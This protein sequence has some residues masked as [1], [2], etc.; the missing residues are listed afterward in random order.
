[1]QKIYFSILF[2]FSLAGIADNGITFKE[3]KN[4][5]PANVLFGADYKS[6]RFFVNDNGFNFCMYDG[7][8]LYSAHQSKHKEK[9]ETRQFIKGHNYNVVFNNASFLKI[10]K[11][12]PSTEYYNYFIGNDESK[13]AGNV[14]AYEEL[15]FSDIYANID[16][17]LYSNNAN[18][19]YD[20]IVKPNGNSNQVELNYESVNSVFIKNDN[21]I[22]ETSV[23]NVTEQKPYAYQFIKGKKIEVLC[24]YKLKDNNTVI[25]DLPNGY[26]EKYDLII[27]PTVIVCSYDNS[28]VWANCHGATYDT[29]GNIFVLGQADAGYPTTAG[30]FQIICDSLYDNVITKYNS[31]GSSKIFTTYV[32]GDNYEFIQNAKVTNN[33]IC[34]FGITYSTNFPTTTN[35]FDRTFNDTVSNLCDLF[36][37][38]LDL[39]GSS[40]LASTYIG[41]SSND[42]VNS[43][44]V[45]TEGGHIGNMLIDSQDN[46]YVTSSTNSINFPTSS[47]AFQTI[48][49]A[50]VD[51]VAFKLDPTLHTLLYSTF[52]GGTNNENAFD[53]KLINGNEILISGTTQS[54]DFPT[55]SG[56]ISPIKNAGRDMYILHLNSTGTGILASTFI[57]SPTNEYA[58]FIDTDENN[59]IYLCGYMNATPSFIQTPGLYATATG[60]ST[61]YKVNSSLS[62]IIYKTKFGTSNFLEYTAFEVDS[63]HNIY[64]AAFTSGI[65]FP[66]TADKFQ[67]HNH[68]SD[69]YVS[70]FNT[71]MLSLKFASYF[72]GR[73]DEHVDGGTSYFTDKGVLYQGICINRGDL[74]TTPGAF[75]TTFPTVDTMAYNDAFVKIDLQ[76]FVTTTSSYGA[77]IKACSPF[78]ANFNSFANTGTNS[79]NFGD[80]SPISYQQ[81][82]S[83]TYNSIG[84]YTVLLIANDSTTCNKTDT[85]KS[86]I[87]VVNPSELKITG[88]TTICENQSVILRA[89]SN[90]AVSYSWSTGA[91]TNSISINTEGTYTATINNGGCD[92]KQTI[93]V[94]YSKSNIDDLFPNV[95]TPNNDNAN[96][97]IDLNKYNFTEVLFTVFDRWGNQKYQSDKIDSVFSP[98]GYTDGTYFYTLNYK[99]ACND[100]EV[101]TKGFIT[102]IK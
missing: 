75:Q 33:S 86:V 101:K 21:L 6:T 63:C 49:N 8:D 79:W 34:V 48:K 62:S 1:M 53:S 68:G 10:Q 18:I 5:W 44:V 36:V 43:V 47:G 57:G 82:T 60:R 40:L 38:K 92:S 3:N 45:A 95:V 37:V 25:Y 9:N 80:G 99:T 58:Y 93:D 96:D 97:N 39:T 98:T 65:T 51:N 70:V 69:L 84:N 14:K 19:K 94:K 4:Q 24:R 12:K 56:V 90:D 100:S 26:N 78:L 27:D 32:G 55:T 91:T 16:L 29:F 11:T 89:E 30:A 83:H 52:F 23:G 28:T 74:P 59:D 88:N 2:F 54:T 22:I 31:T 76:S 35:A 13:W 50:G 17:K 42:G 61:I 87:T 73:N 15:L 71:N 77:E 46:V 81:N 67:D 41:G 72:G 102:I 64:I 20:I 66:V 7:N 85:V